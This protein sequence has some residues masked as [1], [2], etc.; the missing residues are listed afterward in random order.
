MTSEDE[1]I[2]TLLHALGASR[3][4]PAGIGDDGA[5]LEPADGRVCVLDAMVEGVHFD[6]SW[7][8]LSDAAFK[9]FAVNASD[10]WAMG[11]EPRAWL[12]GLGLP[13]RLAD[14][15]SVR[16]IAGGFRD[17][18]RSLDVEVAL[19]GGDTVRTREEAFLSVTMFGALDGEPLVRSA[20]RP[21][22]GVYV[23]GPTGL[24]AAGLELLRSG[25][26]PPP[27]LLNAH[28]RPMPRRL[29]AE[30]ARRAGITAS[31]DV[32]DGL[33]RDA[34]RVAD[35]SSVSITLDPECVPGHE[36]LRDVAGDLGMNALDWVLHGGDDYIRLVTADQRP[37]PSWTRVGSVDA[38]PP[39]VYVSSGGRTARVEPSG[40]EHF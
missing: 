20:A 11:A 13:R 15:D 32:S 10:L 33:V 25:R 9:V 38:G 23:D 24:A 3:P 27:D 29:L 37:G 35:A 28:A 34:E 8:T 2:S 7:T 6:L 31:I 40:F 17:A 19:V 36:R 4:T 39:G 16:A 26:R 30:P 22:Q 12:L 14:A 21:G 18:I 1:I 5:V